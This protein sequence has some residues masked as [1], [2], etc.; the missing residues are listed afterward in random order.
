MQPFPPLDWQ[1]LGIDTKGRSRGSFKTTCPKCSHT[2]RNKTEPC[3]SVD[4]DKNVWRCHHCDWRGPEKGYAKDRGLVGK[5]PAPVGSPLR[6]DERERP[7]LYRKPEPPPREPVQ[8]RM[9]AFFSERG[10]S[11]DTVHVFGIYQG[12]YKTKAGKEIGAICF[13]YRR[14][15]EVINIKYRFPNKRFA[16]E[17]G[18][19]LSF[20][21]LD[22]VQEAE[23]VIICEGEMDVLALY[24]AGYKNVIS[25]PNGAPSENTDIENASLEYMA[26]AEQVLKDAKRVILAGDMDGPG[27]RYMDELARRIGKGKC[28]KVRWPDGCKDANDVL[29]LEGFEGGA[30]GIKV[31]IDMAEPYPVDGITT[32]GSYLEAIF[33][34]RT[35]QESGA[36]ITIWP[37]F[38]K[39]CRFSPGQLS[40]VTGVP[41]SGKSVW[42]NSVIL[43]LAV[44]HGW[45]VGVFSPEYFP[46]EI[47]VRDLVENLTGKVMNEKFKDRLDVEVATDNEVR[48][49][50]ATIDKHIN[51]ILPP[52]PTL[53]QIVERAQTLVYRNGIKMLVIDP[54]TEIDHP[55]RGSMS[56]TDWVD[57]CLKR[58]RR[59]GRE[60]GVHVVI[61][62]HPKKVAPV[63]GKD[64]NRKM[65]VITPYDISDSRHWFEMADNIFSVYRDKSDPNEPVQ[66]HVQKVRFRDN[67]DIG[68][69]LFKYDKWTRRYRDVTGEMDAGDY[70]FES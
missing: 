26:S 45:N 13:P 57:V 7:K 17:S 10:I 14:D 61:V 49:A 41:S 12:T 24:E 29:L 11:A 19:E 64:G 68:L 42:L 3:L 4:L 60:Y 43:D 9:M 16:M 62:A 21:N 5:G 48:A 40:I 47:H 66:V 55:E 70:E 69:A 67:G 6:P 36:R 32:P 33:R 1:S 28:W 53:D 25:P 2:R 39:L 59:F 50:V 56:M 38:S 22:R 18:A 27:Q 46:K 58:L 63:P 37:E 30:S 51:F 44:Q 8:D 15:D 31:A 23:T 34:F 65:P 20:Y 35:D 54:W 52:E